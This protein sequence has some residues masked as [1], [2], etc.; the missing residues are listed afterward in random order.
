MVKGC[1]FK[2]RKEEEGS[3]DTM[4][5]CWEKGTGNGT[6]DPDET[7]EQGWAAGD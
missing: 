2:G 6:G 1:F 5:S 4:R 3:G 7:P